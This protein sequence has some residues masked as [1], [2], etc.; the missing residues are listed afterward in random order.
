MCALCANIIYIHTY[1]HN[2]FD[3]LLFTP[4][5]HSWHVVPDYHTS[6][7][8]QLVTFPQPYGTAYVTTFKTEAG[9][10]NSIEEAN[11]GGGSVCIRSGTATIDALGPTTTNVVE[12]ASF[13]DCTGKLK[14]GECD[15]LAADNLSGVGDDPGITATGEV[16]LDIFWLVTPLK[17]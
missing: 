2:E 16:L 7:R 11:E 5:H 6:E 14:A 15:L 10:Y 1:S 3:Y 4:H 17:R 13:E 12:C 8:S 9:A